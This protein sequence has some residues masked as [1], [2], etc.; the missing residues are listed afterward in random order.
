[1]GYIPSGL[2]PPTAS[3]ADTD[4]AP[5][6]NPEQA[7]DE[8]GMLVS[9]QLKKILTGSIP[10]WIDKIPVSDSERQLIKQK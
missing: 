2:Q 5:Q 4:T 9:K 3:G 7:I 1:M 8:D 10:K 6:V